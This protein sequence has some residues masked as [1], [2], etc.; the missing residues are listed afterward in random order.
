MS[1][2]DIGAVLSAS[3]LAWWDKG[4][5]YSSH[6]RS[7]IET[8]IAAL[9]WKR[10]LFFARLTR[11]CAPLKSGGIHRKG[12]LSWT[13][14]LHKTVY[15]VLKMDIFFYKNASICYMRLLFIPGAGWCV[16]YYGWMPFIWLHLDCWTETLYSLEEQGKKFYNS[17]WIRLKEESHMYLGCLEGSVK[18][19]LI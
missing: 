10:T 1:I 2:R 6:R 4:F 3:E 17:D 11:T 15:I 12:S 8:A 7:S 18:L 19:E 16:C 9:K 5:R 14:N 13:T